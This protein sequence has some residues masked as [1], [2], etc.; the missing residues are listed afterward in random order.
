[1]NLRTGQ[2]ILI[3]K[4]RTLLTLW[5]NRVLKSHPSIYPRPMIEYISQNYKSDPE[6]VGVEIGVY[7]GEGAFFILNTLPIKKLYL[8]DP[9]LEYE[10]FKDTLG[11]EG[12]R[13]TDYDNFFLMA[14]NL[15]KKFKDKI[16]F[17]KKKSEDATGDIPDNLDFVYIDGNHEYEFVKRDIEM[18]YP[19]VKKGGVIGGDNFESSYPSVPRAVLE[20]T[21]KHHLKIH[22]GKSLVSHEWW[23]FKE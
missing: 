6:L 22:G 19:K 21:D 4:G 20:F 1:M 2:L 8:V 11:W 18:Y 13:Q 14:T 5:E 7:A 17:I 16:E 23:V 15:L 10:E 3:R 12:R 9:Y